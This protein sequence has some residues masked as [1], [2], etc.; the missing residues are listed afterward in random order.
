MTQYDPLR[1]PFTLQTFYK[2]P[3][4]HWGLH[5]LPK[6]H[7]NSTLWLPLGFPYT[8]QTSYKQPL[9]TSLGSP[10]SP[11]PNINDPLTP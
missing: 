8:S 5:M 3:P 11:Q 4:R 7:K 6:P 2:R 10:Y 9:T 1:S